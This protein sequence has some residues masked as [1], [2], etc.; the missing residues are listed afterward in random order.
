MEKG[1]FKR[2]FA[3]DVAAGRVVERDIAKLLGHRSSEATRR[4]YLRADRRRP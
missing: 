4:A 3:E 2:L 1:L